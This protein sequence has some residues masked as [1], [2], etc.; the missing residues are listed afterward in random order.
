M[1]GDT[2]FNVGEKTLTWDEL[3]CLAYVKRQG[4]A[5]KSPG[6]VV[7]NAVIDGL[8]SK[9]LLTEA[10]VE[11]AEER[12]EWANQEAEGWYDA[13]AEEIE[14]IVDANLGGSDT[15]CTDL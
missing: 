1:R 2:K 3:A 4:Q 7:H 8:K 10:D 9:G 12:Y 11:G 13:N 15:R 5:T 6:A 14:A